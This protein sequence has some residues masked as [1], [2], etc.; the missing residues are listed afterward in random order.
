MEPGQAVGKR[1]K[2]SDVIRD[3]IVQDLLLSGEVSPGDRLPTE[4]E[5]CRRYAASRVTV[6]AALRSLQEAGYI[7][8]RQGLGSTVLPRPQVIAS[9][10]DR[11]GS[12]ETFAADQ[13]AD[14][15]SAELEVSMRELTDEEAAPFHMEGGSTG[16]VIS[17]VKVY[18][19]DRV[20]WIVDYLPSGVLPFEIV[21]R[22]FRGSVLD[23]LL[24]HPELGVEYS[25]CDLE[26]VGL[27]DDIATHLQVAPG[28]PAMYL[29][30]LTRNQA[31]EV[32]NVSR[33]WLLTDYFHLHLRRRRHFGN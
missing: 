26:A 15:S 27:P 20:A 16:L 14:V 22:E 9:G 33:A 11:L 19:S 13:G 31:A 30:E 24:A 3:A 25:D 5:L 2:L 4:A 23:V 8:V 17:R 6:R 1:P 21:Q 28:T 12:L 18:D 32:V 7:A 10:L 29:E